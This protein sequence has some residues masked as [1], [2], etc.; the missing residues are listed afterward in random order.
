MNWNI[1][2][3]IIVK[4][5]CMRLL[6]ILAKEYILYDLERIGIITYITLL[7]F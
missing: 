2:G 4:Y 3:F 7:Y 6:L 1:Y 5:I